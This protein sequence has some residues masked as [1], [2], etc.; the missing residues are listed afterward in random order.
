MSS[1]G[2]AEFGRLRSYLWPIHRGELKKLLPMLLM[3]F[4]ITFDYNILRTMKD[5][6][7]VTAKDSGAEIIPFI[8]VWVMFP[9]SILL[10]YIFTRLS[11]RLARETV[12]YV[13]LSIFLLFFVSFA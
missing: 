11:N 10:T 4:F 1:S 7:V 5:S 6:L 13:M 3:F 8:K 2:N 9:G 12:F